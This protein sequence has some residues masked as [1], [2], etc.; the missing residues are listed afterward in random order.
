MERIRIAEAVKRGKLLVSDGAWGTEL[1]LRGLKQGECPE[2][3][4]LEN[5]EAVYDVALNYVNAGADMIKTNSFG[6][7]RLNL[8]HYG[9]SGRAR[10]IN[11]EAAAISRRA[12]GG[13]VWVLGS[14]GPS[15]KLLF[16][17]QTTEAALYE[18][19]A[20]QAAALEAGGADAVLIETMSDPAE[21]CAAVRA[22]KENTRLEII[23]T[24][25]FSKTRRGEYRTLM[26]TTPEDAVSA[27]I[28]AGADI[29][30]ANCGNGIAGM[31]DIA[32]KIKAAAG[33]LPVIIH[34]N[35]G[36]PEIADT[37]V[38]YRETPEYMASFVRELANAGANII[39]GCCGTTPA[40][41]RA[42][43]GAASVLEARG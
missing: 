32:A 15:G 38:V 28:G 7:T 22:A 29:V 40:H 37:G 9:L 2:L 25:T 34:S 36:L 31:V 5:P 14:V 8:E 30:G 12:A 33:A 26:G 21:A 17:Q 27:A 19:F 39:G 35:A 11:A 18:A 3:M 10:E 16:M 23:C 41:I 1:F 13:G 24:F 6:G 42:I 20:E 43:R 4:N